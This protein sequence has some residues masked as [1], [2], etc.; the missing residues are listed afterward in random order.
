M[1]HFRV[2]LLLA[3][4]LLTSE[5][6]TVKYPS[7]SLCLVA[8]G[9]GIYSLE[10]SVLWYCISETCRMHYSRFRGNI[11]RKATINSFI[12]WGIT[13][14]F[15]WLAKATFPFREQK[16]KNNWRSIWIIEAAGEPWHSLSKE[17][18]ITMG[19]LSHIW[20]S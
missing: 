19:Q 12:D 6:L 17:Y 11:N 18:T 13:D 15:S 7:V 1:V 2:S 14:Y 9:V 20:N 4:I 16:T 8:V 10:T 5:N 3:F